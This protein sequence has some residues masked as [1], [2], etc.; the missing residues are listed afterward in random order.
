LTGGSTATSAGTR[1]SRTCSTT[2]GSCRSRP[3]CSATA[4]LDRYYGIHPEAGAETLGRHGGGEPHDPSQFYYRRNGETFNGL[5]V[6]S[7]NLTPTGSRPLRHLSCTGEPRGQLRASRRGERCRRDAGRTPRGGGRPRGAG[8][9][10]RGLHRGADTRHRPLG[11]RPPAP[12]AVR[13]GR[14]RSPSKATPWVADHQRRALFD[15]YSPGRAS[16]GDPT[17]DRHPE[18]IELTACREKPLE[19]PHV[20]E[21]P[22]PSEED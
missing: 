10:G 12:G 16:W 13:S 5:T 19:S 14:P 18:G 3:R 2:T 8:R 22:G 1:R 17:V 7:W 11:R 4:W 6:V 20:R 9:V 15:E 21:R